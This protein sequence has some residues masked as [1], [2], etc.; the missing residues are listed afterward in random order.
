M[1]HTLAE[2]II[3]KHIGGKSVKPGDLVVVEPDCVVIHDI[4]TAFLQDKM[5]KM[6]LTKVWNTD[7]IVIMHDHLMPACLEGDPRSLEAGYELVKEYGIRHF[8]A[9]GG[10]VH[11]LVPELGY[12]KPG[13]I[14][15]IFKD[16]LGMGNEWFRELLGMKCRWTE[17]SS[18]T[19]RYKRT[20]R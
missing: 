20:R 4:Y 1:G 10:I 5:K 11:Q 16:M 9:T 19:V 17:C 7:K 14:V 8:H 6:G 18:F 2:K 3:M 12:S 15:L 13:D